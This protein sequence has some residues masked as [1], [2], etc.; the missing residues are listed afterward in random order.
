LQPDGATQQAVR[1]GFREAFG[2]IIVE[3]SCHHW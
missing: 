1:R 3:R 2:I